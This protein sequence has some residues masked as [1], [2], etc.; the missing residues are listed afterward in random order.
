MY[1]AQLYPGVSP[2]AVAQSTGFAMDLSR[3]KEAK[4]PSQRELA[5][6]RQQV[7]PQRLILG[8]LPQ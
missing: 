5:T 1:L 2:Q 6:L 8:P 7:D 3:A 4:P